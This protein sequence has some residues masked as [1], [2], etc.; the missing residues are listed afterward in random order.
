M[1]IREIPVEV[2]AAVRRGVVIPAQPLALNAGHRFDWVRQQALTRYY[3]DA[4][5]GGVQRV[6]AAEQGVGR[7][8]FLDRLRV[9]S[10]VHQPFALEQGARAGR[11]AAREQG[12]QENEPGRVG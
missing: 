11:R 6:G 9:F 12:Q 1:L 10:L 3:I 5:A 2:L 7:P 4:G 8:Q